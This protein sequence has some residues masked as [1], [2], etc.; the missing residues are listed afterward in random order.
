MFSQIVS[1]VCFNPTRRNSTPELPV[2]INVLEDRVL[3][4]SPPDLGADIAW[5]DDPNTNGNQTDYASPS[6]VVAAFNHGRRREEALLRL[7]ANSLGNLRLPGDWESLSPEDKGLHLVNAERTAR[8][9][10]QS[11][12]PGLPLAGIEGNIQQLAQAYSNYLVSTNQWTHNPRGG[13]F[14]G[15][16]PFSRLD[17]NAAL[18]TSAGCHEFLPFAENLAV[19][20]SSNPIPMPVERSIYNFIYA[21]M[22]S[23]WLHRQ[24]ILVQDESLSGSPGYDNNYGANN[25]EGFMGLVVVERTNGSYDP[26][27][28][29]RSH[30]TLVTQLFFDPVDDSSCD[31]DDGSPKSVELSINTAEASEADR[32]AVTITARASGSVSGIQ[33]VDI[34]I[35]GTGISEDDYS[36][37]DATITIPD[38]RNTGSV[39]LTV[40][41]DTL[42]ETTETLSVALRNFSSGIVAGDSTS[43]D[44]TITDNDAARFSIDDVSAPE[45]DGM[46]TFS[47][48]TNRPIDIATRLDVSFT[49]GT[50]TAGDDFDAR[51][52]RVTIPAESTDPQ[53]VTVN[54]VNDDDLEENET[55]TA[56]LNVTTAPGDRQF[57][58]SDTGTATITNDDLPPGLLVEETHDRTAIGEIGN[59]DSIA[60]SLTTRPSSDV[61]LQ[62]SSDA[63][64]D[65]AVS[66]AELTFTASNWNMA[67]DVEVVGVEDDA[68]DGD[69]TA[70][71]T[72]SVKEQSNDAYNSV[73][74]STVD[75]TIFDT[76]DKAYLDIDGDNSTLP[77]TDG[78]LALRHAAGFSGA[79]LIDGAVSPSASRSDSGAIG[80]W[81]TEADFVMLDVDAD[82]S[83]LPLSDGLLM[84]RFIAGFSGPGLTRDAVSESATRT[85]PEAIHEFLS[86]FLVPSA[87]GGGEGSAAAFAMPAQDGRDEDSLPI[88]ATS[89]QQ[90]GEFQLPQQAT[91]A[92]AAD[93]N[94]GSA[95]S[96]TDQDAFAHQPAQS[97]AVSKSDDL[98]ELEDLFAGPFNWLA[99]E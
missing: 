32:T 92:S 36:L 72:I 89:R 26:F 64:N 65:V 3:L 68:V 78:I 98:S 38:G 97:A 61:V 51:T 75:V 83:I 33:T 56:S 19:F 34:A 25:S 95:M 10:S 53:T 4:T 69:Q 79:G 76:T 27:G 8:G 48:S 88:L 35:T 31:Y 39:T 20:W 21:D 55:F 70:V 24:A 58:A 82:G 73:P 1:R 44:V 46:V 15:T 12:I 60:V 28:N 80:D 11:D 67:Q 14:G 87:G 96:L 6:D 22:G 50:A 66:P 41:N 2:E 71:V 54:I 94:I 62:I 7:P 63:A 30:Q 90:A 59:S 9:G 42:V 84:I 5:D 18:G 74:N 40:R 13:S 91:N 47:V 37:S 49:E 17:Q 45:A 16:D 57:N 85:S 93:L 23:A 81:L 43:A 86:L 52:V 29:G 77:L 99:G